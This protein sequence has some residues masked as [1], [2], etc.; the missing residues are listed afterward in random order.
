M[1]KKELKLHK[2]TKHTTI[3]ATAKTQFYKIE[4]IGID[5][6]NWMKKI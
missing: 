5:R 2:I 3:L 1:A 4:S 6:E